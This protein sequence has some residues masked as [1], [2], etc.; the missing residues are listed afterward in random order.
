[1]P[2]AIYPAR[3][4]EHIIFWWNGHVFHLI[5]QDR[6]GLANGKNLDA[7]I[8][9][10]ARFINHKR[11]TDDVEPTNRGNKA[12][13]GDLAEHHMITMFTDM[14]TDPKGKWI[15]EK[16]S[17]MDTQLM[18]QIANL[19]VESNKIEQKLYMP[20]LTDGQKRYYYRKLREYAIVLNEL[21]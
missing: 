16:E 17:Q 20:G 13:F 10:E 4:P 5:S 9:D 21:R 19:Q 2:S 1:I 14:P 11:Y 15:L 8:V 6:P 3:T 18:A 12:V 7:M